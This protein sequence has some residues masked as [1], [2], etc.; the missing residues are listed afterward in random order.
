MD[1][2]LYGAELV[3]T[4]AFALSGAMLAAHKGLDLFGVVFLGVV[5]AL[6]GTPVFVL[7]LS[8]TRKVWS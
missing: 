6:V 4:V 7:L 2:V 8:Q 1:L 3:G 5:T